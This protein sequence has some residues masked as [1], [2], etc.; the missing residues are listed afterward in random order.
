LSL[1]GV[2]FETKLERK[3][4]IASIALWIFCREQ[5]EEYNRKYG[6]E[7]L[8]SSCPSQNGLNGTS[9]LRLAQQVR[10]YVASHLRGKYLWLRRS[11]C[12]HGRHSFLDIAKFLSY[13]HLQKYR[14]HGGYPTNSIKNNIPTLVK[15]CESNFNSITCVTNIIPQTPTSQYCAS[16]GLGLT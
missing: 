14:G 16:S 15:A 4:R 10:I 13:F 3:A 2:S 11:L 12:Q 1:C 6:N 5:Q 7:Y 8:R 9:S